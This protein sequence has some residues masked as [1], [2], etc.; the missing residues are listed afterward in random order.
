M[1]ISSEQ[2]GF[3]MSNF[4]GKFLALLT[5]LTLTL[6]SGTVL[7][8]GQGTVDDPIVWRMGG[9]YARGVSYGK[10]YEYFAENVKRLSGGR[11]IIEV[12]YDNEGIS[13]SELLS[14]VRTGLLEMANPFQALH[15]GEFPAGVV[16]LG[17]PDGPED[18]LEIR[19]MFREGG[20]LEGMRKA[21]ASIGVYYLGEAPN[22][23]T[24]LLTKTPINSL[25]DL[26]Q[27]KIRCPGAYG[28]KLA[29]LGASTVTMALSEVYSSLA[30]GLLDGVDGCTILDHYEIKSYEMAKYIY[31]LPVA[32]SQVIGLIANLEAFNALPDD[33]KAILE[34]ATEMYA[35]DVLEKSVVWERDALNK[36]LAAGLQ[37]SPEPSPEDVKSWHEAGRK[38]WTEYAQK[39]AFC[40][41]LLDLQTKFMKEL[42]YDF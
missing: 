21:Y 12:M 38:V 5:A 6:C 11:M 14:G 8:A 16:E 19:A 22:P 7:A 32:N 10:T 17:L 4:C 23:G 28:Q 30:S 25:E 26:K 39:D 2:G 36:M 3:P 37:W 42:G 31:K 9:L 15:A 18:L 20:W 33:L 41:E 40:K 13:A 1:A 29:N 35:N 24:F 34:G 27:M